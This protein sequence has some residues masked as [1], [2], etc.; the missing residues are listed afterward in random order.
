V[1]GLVFPAAPGNLAFE[2]IFSYVR[3]RTESLGTK[4]QYGF[5]GFLTGFPL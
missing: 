3:Y 2:Y 4:G 1:R 5:I